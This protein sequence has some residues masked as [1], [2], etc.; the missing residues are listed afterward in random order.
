MNFVNISHHINNRSYLKLIHQYF[1]FSINLHN[2]IANGLLDLSG[3]SLSVLIHLMETANRGV[4]CILVRES[5]TIL[6][7]YYGMKTG[8]LT[9]THY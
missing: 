6:G 9:L 1:P 3:D 7:H 4:Q 8:S 5:L 2:Q